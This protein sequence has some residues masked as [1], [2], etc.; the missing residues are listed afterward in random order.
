MSIVRCAD[1]SGRWIEYSLGK[2]GWIAHRTT[3]WTTTRMAQ[4]DTE[5]VSGIRCIRAD[6]WRGNV[7]H[8]RVAISERASLRRSGQAPSTSQAPGACQEGTERHSRTS[9][10]ERLRMDRS[11]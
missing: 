4:D 9:D 10:G 7:P 3:D 5:P 1:G 8:Q 11:K 2:A 6:S